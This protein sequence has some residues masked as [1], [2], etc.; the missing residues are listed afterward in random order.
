[1]RQRP[2]WG[3][4]GALPPRPARLL[5]RPAP[6]PA[7]RCR[8]A[9]LPCPRARPRALPAATASDGGALAILTRDAILGRIADGSLRIDP[10]DPAQVGPASVDLH[11]DRQFRVFRKAHQVVHITEDIEQSDVTDLLEVEDHFL[12]LPGEAALGLTVERLT[13]PDDLCGWLE[14]RSRFA[15][16]GLMIHITAS[17]MQPGIDNRQV[18]EMSNAGPFPLAIHPGIAVCQFIFSECVGHAHYAGRFDR[19]LSL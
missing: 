13:L 1:M 3:R 8:P 4:S 17:F 18:L 14:G 7:R 9:T 19:Q 10:F 6:C 16:V 5:V 15:R 2:T 11:L 12:L